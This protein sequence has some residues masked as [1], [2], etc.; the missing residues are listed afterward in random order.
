MSKEEIAEAQRRAAAC[1]AKPETFNQPRTAYSATAVTN[2]PGPQASGTG[3]FVTEDGYLATSFHLIDG[4]TRILIKTERGLLPARLVNADKVNDVAILK[5]DGKFA[6]MPVVPS[7]AT[8]IGEIVF[9]IGFPDADL[10]G[11]VP[12][13]TQAAI[14]SLTGAQ[15][16]PRE[17]QITAAVQPRN[18]GGPLVNQYGNVV[19]VVGARPAQATPAKANPATVQNVNYAVKSSLLSVLLESLPE[20]SSK[21]KEPYPPKDRKLDDI[22]KEAQSATALVLV[23]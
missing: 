8:K 20:T 7:R 5:A 2:P 11:L 13:V 17:F 1:V 18:S 22:V 4:A 3:F 14:S 6:D 10:Q 21:L 16:D 19:G 23:Y 9:A 12:K 15:N